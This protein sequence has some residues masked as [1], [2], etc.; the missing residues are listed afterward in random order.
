MRYMDVLYNFMKLSLGA[1]MNWF[2]LDWILGKSKLEI[3]IIQFFAF[4]VL[5]TV[6]DKAFKRLKQDG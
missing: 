3:F 6:I 4:L 5:Y 1:L 2:L